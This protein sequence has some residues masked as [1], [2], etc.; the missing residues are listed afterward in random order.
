[1][2]T[3]LATF[4]LL[5]LLGLGM[6]P[7]T[8]RA[9]SM[10]DCTNGCHVVTCTGDICS[11]WRCDAK[12]C[13]LLTTYYRDEKSQPE[14]VRGKPAAVA[15]GAD[16]VKVCPPGEGCRVYE[17]TAR[18]ALLLGSFDNIDDIVAYRKAMRISPPPIG[19]G[20]SRR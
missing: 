1:M 16:Y 9:E 14:A 18:E 13:R 8:A 6:T 2:K 5:I 7:G 10:H 15:A 12:G 3:F 17:L 20:R 19:S 11:V 4:A